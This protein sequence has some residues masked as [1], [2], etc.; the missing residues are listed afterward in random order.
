MARKDD[1]ISLG[2]GIKS[3][4]VYRLESS[5]LIFNIIHVSNVCRAHLVRM[6]E[7]SKKA[8]Y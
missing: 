5:M 3:G 2:K 8:A 7:H 1:R 4:N 6:N